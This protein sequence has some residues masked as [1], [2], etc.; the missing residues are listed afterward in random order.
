MRFIA[1]AVAL[2]AATA[3]AKPADVTVVAFV[4]AHCKPCRAERPMLDALAKK[5]A[6]DGAVRVRRVG[7]DGDAGAREYVRLFGGDALA[8]PR[9]A[10]VDRDG[11]GLERQGA[12]AG[13]TSDD[14]VRE[15]SA[16]IESVRAHAPAP[17]TP[18]WTA[19][20]RR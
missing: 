10:V 6:T 8:V 11:R 9:L 12:R 15:V 13:E 1:V 18:M 2:V 4:S 14:F 16:A 7:V 19:L 20:S 5:Y 17:P 3:H